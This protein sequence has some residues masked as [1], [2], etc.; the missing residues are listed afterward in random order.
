GTVRSTDRRDRYVAVVPRFTVRAGH[1]LL[2]LPE[3]CGLHAV[4]DPVHSHLPGISSEPLVVNQARQDAVA[5]FTAEGFR[6]AAVTAIGF[7]RASMVLPSAQARQV[8]V[9]VDRPFGFAAVHRDSGLVLVAGWV[10]DPP[11][12]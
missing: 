11:T 12:G 1:D 7:V 4:A 5:E 8:T 9:T 3:V 10:A 2:A 6:A